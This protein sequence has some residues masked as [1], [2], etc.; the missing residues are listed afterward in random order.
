MTI[1]WKK[2]LF[3]ISDEKLD[4]YFH[5][6]RT[7]E[8]KLVEV[9]E[10]LAKARERGELTAEQELKLDAMIEATLAQPHWQKR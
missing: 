1:N 9:K 10:A 4:P 6:E 7:E 2:I 8:Y 3:G 5:L